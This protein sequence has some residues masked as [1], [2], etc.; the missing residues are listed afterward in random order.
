MQAVKDLCTYSSLTISLALKGDIST[1]PYLSLEGTGALKI[2]ISF[3]SFVLV[4]KIQPIIWFEE[5]AV[6]LFL[7]LLKVRA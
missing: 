6:A 7:Y 1:Q 4:Y 5:K 2:V 3:A